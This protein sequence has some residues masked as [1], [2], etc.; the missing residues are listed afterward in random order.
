MASTLEGMETGTGEGGAILGTFGSGI[1]GK[2]SAGTGGAFEA[3]GPG[4][5]AVGLA[6]GLAVV[7]VVDWAAGDGTDATGLAGIC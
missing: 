3:A 4:R 6:I 1:F 5:L 2:L 7:W